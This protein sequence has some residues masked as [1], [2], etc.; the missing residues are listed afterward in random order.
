MEVYTPYF[1][2]EEIREL[3]EAI[4]YMVQA[5]VKPGEP[6]ECVVIKCLRPVENALFSQLSLRTRQAD[7]INMF[8]RAARFVP[9]GDIY[10]VNILGE[11][12]DS[13]YTSFATFAP[14][15]LDM[16]KEVGLL[17]RRY[18][19]ERRLDTVLRGASP[20]D[21]WRYESMVVNNLAKIHK[22]LPDLSETDHHKWGTT[23]QL[24]RKYSENVWGDRPPQ[25][26]RDGTIN[27]AALQIKDGWVGSTYEYISGKILAACQTEDMTMLKKYSDLYDSLNNIVGVLADVFKPNSII[28]SYLAARHA[29]RHIKECHGDT[30]EKNTFIL[31]N[32]IS[33]DGEGTRE[34]EVVVLIDPTHIRRFYMIDTLSE[35]AMRLCTLAMDGTTEKRIT[36]LRDEYLD[37]CLRGTGEQ[38]DLTATPVLNF[39]MTEKYLALAGVRYN[40]DAESER[41]EIAIQHGNASANKLREHLNNNQA[42]PAHTML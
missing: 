9:P 36:E 32:T 25:Y 26:L 24:Y 15:D 19:E 12:E 8:E 18:P 7:T 1:N 21:R 33:A 27:Y 14:E 29:G 2:I 6:I 40:L 35:L 4:L 37:E 34:C 28:R 17:M 3:G 41:T 39:Y 23:D 16:S 22:S 11:K 38:I 30:T 42:T 31:R 20:K 10:L 5:P 13:L